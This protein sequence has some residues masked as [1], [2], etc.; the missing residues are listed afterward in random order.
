MTSTTTKDENC[1]T[2][3]FWLFENKK[4]RENVANHRECDS[5]FFF[6][7]CKIVGRILNCGFIERKKKAS[8][9][10]FRP[11]SLAWSRKDKKKHKFHLLLLLV[12]LLSLSLSLSHLPPLSLSFF[13]YL[14]P[15][16]LLLLGWIWVIRSYFNAIELK[17][18]RQKRNFLLSWAST[19]SRKKLI[20]KKELKS[21]ECETKTHFSSTKIRCSCFCNRSW[22]SS[23][24]R[25]VTK[26]VKA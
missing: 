1:E 12:R 21:V 15:L 24:L 13:I 5:T 6:C 7:C 23:I 20:W 10:Q 26:E 2:L 19:A 9:F 22:M 8:K 25:K 16:L 18:R 3:K 14:F 11:K 17:Q 4:A